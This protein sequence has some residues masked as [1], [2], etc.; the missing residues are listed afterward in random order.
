MDALNVNTIIS[1]N[2]CMHYISW[3]RDINHFKIALLI[4]LAIKYNS[5][6]LFV[7]YLFYQFDLAFFCIGIKNNHKIKFQ[8]LLIFFVLFYHWN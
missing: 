6:I 7:E 4:F 1:N 2:Y 8:A 5:K 3:Q